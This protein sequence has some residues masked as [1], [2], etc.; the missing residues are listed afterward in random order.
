MKRL[1]LI[2]LLFIFNSCFL[3]PPGAPYKYE[4]IALEDNNFVNK[5]QVFDIPN[6]K[7]YHFFA[8]NDVIVKACSKVFLDSCFHFKY[9]KYL[10]T[11]KYVKT[12]RIKDKKFLD[13]F[14]KDTLELFINDH[15]ILFVPI[16][17]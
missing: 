11:L 8:S 4:Y 7:T 17:K 10:D 15:K 6:L 3:M 14:K 16:I 13:R 12:I 9:Q 5:I 2:I 1:V